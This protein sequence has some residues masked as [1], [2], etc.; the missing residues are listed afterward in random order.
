[1]QRTSRVLAAGADTCYFPFQII[2]L[3]E[4]LVNGAQ[5][6]MLGLFGVLGLLM[7]GVAGGSLL[8]RGD[9]APVGDSGDDGDAVPEGDGDP[10]SAQQA[11]PDV[12]A[13]RQLWDEGEDDPAATPVSQVAAM[14]GPGT[15]DAGIA[16]S[17]NGGAGPPGLRIDGGDRN[18]GLEG[19][20]QDDTLTGGA[21]DDQMNGAEGN[22]LM[23]GD[24]GRDTMHGGY[25]FD[26]LDGGEG[27]DALHGHEAD[28]LL[29]GGDGDDTLIGG[30][31]HDT[32]QGGAGAD[33]LTGGMGDDLLLAGPGADTLDGDAGNDTLQG[34]FGQQPDGETRFLNAGD[35]DD[36]LR[37]GAGDMAT[38]GDGSDRFEMAADG[39]LASILDFDAAA[40]ELVVLYDPAGPLPEVTLSAGALPDEVVIVVNG[41]PVA[42]VVGAGGLTPEAIRLVAS[43]G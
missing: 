16:G 30:N 28:D 43:Q 32:L 20:L 37:V 24:A 9:A 38:G 14:T 25:G 15:D 29:Q 34:A 5:G 41:Q 4:I 35:G 2:G 3:F 27:D 21:G 1:M 6:V 10:A 12:A 18:D 19:G 13:V 39:G 26:T 31:G 11:A 7:A 17:G 36:V 40:D 22:D 33:W 23:S 8:M 42:Q